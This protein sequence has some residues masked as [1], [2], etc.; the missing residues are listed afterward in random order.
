MRGETVASW[1]AG[2]IGGDPSHWRGLLRLRGLRP[3]APW[4]RL[5]GHERRTVARWI[6]AMRHH[7]IQ[8]RAGAIWEEDP[9]VRWTREALLGFV[10]HAEPWL[11]ADPV[12]AADA[13]PTPP[14]VVAAWDAPPDVPRGAPLW[15]WL[16]PP[17][18]ALQGWPEPV[19][20]CMGLLVAVT[21]V[22]PLAA[23]AHH[24]V[25]S[26]PPG[27]LSAIWA[28]AV[29]SGGRGAAPP[30][31]PAQ[32]VRERR[33]GTGLTWRLARWPHG[34][35]GL[36]GPGGL[37]SA[38]P[39]DPEVGG[40]L[41][42][43]SAQPLRAPESPNPPG[44]L[45][46]VPLGHAD[47][48]PRVY[49]Q[50]TH[51]A[52]AEVAAHWHQR[53]KM[54]GPES[55]A[56]VVLLTGRR[57]EGQ[58]QAAMGLTAGLGL[59]LQRLHPGRLAARYVGETEKRLTALFRSLDPTRTALFL[60]DGQDLMAPRVEVDSANARYANMASNHL[61]GLLDTWPGLCLVCVPSSTALDPA[62]ARRA[63]VHVPFPDLRA[64]RRELLLDLLAGWFRARM[65]IS[66]GPVGAP[67]PAVADALTQDDWIQVFLDA[68]FEA[69][70]RG[71]PLTRAAVRE[72]A[73]LLLQRRGHAVRQA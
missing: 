41:P 63:R 14:T 15:A 38:G 60:E 37:A 70:R 52:L 62:F 8:A 55:T 20:R 54:G 9:L 29:A 40:Q 58:L 19:A 30:K 2:Q 61:L 57:G 44:T 1:V 39:R 16:S 12:A 73:A 45:E 28:T 71:A 65:P 46:P 13:W 25:P 4:S 56:L 69:E 22:P 6:E 36:G 34:R 24:A 10:R 26:L 72:R 5:S 67:L 23:V 18:A 64:E 68:A 27:T 66:H 17:P 47:D 49:E 33:V 31:L 43:P 53:D 59:E 3:D 32:W 35:E 42:H 11:L 7:E 48:P 50:A 51:Q 21:A